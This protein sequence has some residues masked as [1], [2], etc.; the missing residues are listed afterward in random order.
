MI[1]CDKGSLDRDNA[2]HSTTGLGW[3]RARR[4]EGGQGLKAENLAQN[5]S[6]H[7]SHPAHC[8]SALRISMA[9]RETCIYACKESC[10]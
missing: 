8:Y 9:Q 6:P 5:L 3:L 1:F 10:K 2:P 7:P 4:S